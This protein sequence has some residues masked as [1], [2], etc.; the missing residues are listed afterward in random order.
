VRSSTQPQEIISVLV[1][2]SS[3]MGAQLIAGALK[4]CR[5]NFTIFGPTCSCTD[6]IHLAEEGAPHVAVISTDLQE[7]PLSG[8][9][10]LQQIRSCGLPTAAVMLTDKSES[11]VVIDSF[12]GGARGVFSR[13]SSLRSLA[14]CIRTVHSGACQRLLDSCSRNLLTFFV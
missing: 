6:A 10:V 14:K 12:C 13:R 4:R 8:F 5:N 11:E 3:M 1:A 9:K 7:G 2:E